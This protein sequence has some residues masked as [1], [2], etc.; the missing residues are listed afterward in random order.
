[1]K[2]KKLLA[3][4]ILLGVLV[5]AIAFGLY[6][7]IEAANQR[8]AIVTPDGPAKQ[9]PD[10]AAPGRQRRVRA[11][12]H[13]PIVERTLFSTDRNPIIEVVT[14]AEPPPE[15]RQQRARLRHE[16]RLQRLAGDAR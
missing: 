8:Y 7:R 3:L 16:A 13:L 9:I 14:P 12:D 6:S 2:N 10:H 11:G 1:M 5:I 15:P 4:N